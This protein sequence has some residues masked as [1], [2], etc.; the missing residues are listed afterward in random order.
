MVRAKL[1]AARK[2][3]G[4]TQ[5][6]M[7]HLLGYRSKAQYCMLERGQRRVTVET[8]FRIASILNKPIEEL[9]DASEVHDVR[10][11]NGD[12]PATLDAT[13]TH[14]DLTGTEGR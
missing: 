12:Q 6:Q 1:K 4:L 3:A 9:F 10:T 14:F 5:G 8:A 11:Q 13:G 7:A 2:A